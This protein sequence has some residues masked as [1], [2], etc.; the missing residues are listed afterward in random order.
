MDL[1]YI[2]TTL[3]FAYPWMFIFPVLFLVLRRL[4]KPLPAAVP[5][6]SSSDLDAIPCGWRARCRKPL[7]GVLALLMVSSF[8]IAAARPQ[9]LS[10]LPSV[11]QA[12]NLML[13]IDV[14]R[15]MDT[16]DF[17]SPRGRVS[18]LQAVKQVLPQFLAARAD[19]RVGLV[20][21]GSSAFLQSPLTTD[22]ETL[23]QLVEAI[24]VG[25]A[26]DGTAIGDGLGLSLKRLRNAAQGS[27]AVV[28]LTDGVN[29]AGEVD[30][31]KA[32]SVAKDLGIKVH[33]IGIGSYDPVSQ[34]G[35][36]VFFPSHR[37]EPEFDEQTLRRIAEVTGGVY[38]N[39]S[40]IEGLEK[41]YAAL[42]ELAKSE[43]DEPSQ[44]LVEELYFPYAVIGFFALLLSVLAKMVLFPRIP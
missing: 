40:S 20:V 39:A 22:H 44:R 24:P 17:A 19:D 37:S 8:T 38:Q 34:G 14:S 7:L 5:V 18:R 28:L 4:P 12:R 9:R 41:V 43:D 29:N 15:S 2:F 3:S 13:A 25:V 32:A 16:V 23:I 31:L 36:G 11:K 21:F 1:L 33:T 10:T 26:G 27:T 30:P 42:D 35:A 6:P